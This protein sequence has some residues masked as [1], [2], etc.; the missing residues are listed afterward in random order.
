MCPGTDV[1]LHRRE[2]YVAQLPRAEYHAMINTFPANFE[3]TFGL[4]RIDSCGLRPTMF[5]AMR[6]LRTHKLSAVRLLVTWLITCRC[7][8]LPLV[9]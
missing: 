9:L 6:Q 5:G 2:E 3:R 8:Q 4:R 7:P 1:F